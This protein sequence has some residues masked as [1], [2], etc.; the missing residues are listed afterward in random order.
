VKE[1]IDGHYKPYDAE[2]EYLES[3]GTQYIDTG[4]VMA[5]RIIKAQ[6]K[7]SISNIST[8]IP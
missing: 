3:N 1:W 2:V 7:I 6:Y 8:S 5:N 4:I